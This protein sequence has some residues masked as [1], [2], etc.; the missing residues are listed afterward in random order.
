M[1]PLS[2]GSP[3]LDVLLER[4]QAGDN[5]V[6]YSDGVDEYVPFARAAAQFARSTGRRLIYVRG[7][8]LF[9]HQLA[10]GE[11]TDVWDLAELGAGYVIDALSR[12]AMLVAPEAY[13]LFE[14]LQSLAPWL[15]DESHIVQ[16]FLAWCPLL[17]RRK[18][19]AYWDL[20][21]GAFRAPAIAAIQGCT[22]IFLRL[23]R[24][25]PDLVL[26]PLKVWGRYSER[27]FEPHRVRLADPLAVEPMPM[28]SSERVQYVQA[29]ADK[30]RELAEVR[31]ALA[32][33]NAELLAQ[34][35]ELESLHAQVL[36]QGRLY[37]SLRANLDSLLALFRAGWD[38]GS[39]LALDRVYS[40]ILEAAR[41]VF[42]APRSTLRVEAVGERP[43]V[44]LVS[45][46][47]DIALP[48]FP[49]HDA[50]TASSLST[51][52]S[53]VRMSDSGQVLSWASAPIV[54]HARSAGTLTVDVIGDRL[55][56]EESRRLLEYLASESSIALDNAYLYCES[57]QQK[58]QLRSFV[59]E[60][61]L[62]QEQESRELALNLHDGLVQLIVA[63]FQH[64]QTA[65]AWRGRDPV[66]EERE[67][68]RGL[69]ILQQSIVEARR[70]IGRL[71]PAGLDDFGLVHA[72]RAL[73]TQLAADESWNVSLEV[74][75][76]WCELGP[77]LEAG[78]FRIVQ[79]ATANIRK[80]AEA[81]RVRIALA[82]EDTELI[83]SVRD[84]GKGFDPRR[85]D[86][87]PERGLHIGLVGIRE[88]ALLF[89]G[90]CY[91]NSVPGQ[92]TTIT[93]RVPRP[94]ADGMGARP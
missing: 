73:V 81:D 55:D 57:D 32:T 6:F 5:V 79:E 82:V 78:L 7:T 94:N 21:R 14:P 54:L 58:A 61:M 2:T 84:W 13:Y 16:A 42:D 40:E 34:Y 85:V 71:R 39:S 49:E 88:R 4:I 3:D 36:E 87:V 50:Y 20:G 72:L 74:D 8:G 25:S 63:S 23:D 28:G 37:Q 93:V 47:P 59:D 33:S 51:A 11:P 9:D 60:V 90:S 38:I 30:N 43:A 76:A 35:T 29:M 12:R 31:D 27:M 1:R 48:V 75:P 92:G 80:Y 68:E 19:I 22:Q 64:L 65:K 26:T 77:S 17:F 83:V 15:G 86:S 91:V 53:G 46:L 41:R 67:V 66:V 69:Q 89:G 62:T 24:S 52:Q 10:H 45:A 18:S 44:E 56:S 70:V